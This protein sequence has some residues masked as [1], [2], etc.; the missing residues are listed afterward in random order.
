MFD[1]YAIAPSASQLLLINA[2]IAGERELFFHVEDSL[3]HALDNRER[4]PNT[5]MF[6][7]ESDA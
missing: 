2:R 1:P 6:E 5:L 4:I 7:F 3:S